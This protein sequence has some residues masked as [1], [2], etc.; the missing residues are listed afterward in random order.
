[1]AFR[2]PSILQEYKNG[3]KQEFTYTNVH[4]TSKTDKCNF[5]SKTDIIVYGK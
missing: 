1:M 5:D 2:T 4:E 3:F